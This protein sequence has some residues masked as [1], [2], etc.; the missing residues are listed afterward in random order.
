MINN[1][2]KCFKFTTKTWWMM[3][4][5]LSSGAGRTSVGGWRMGAG[6]VYDG[7]SGVVRSHAWGES[8][9]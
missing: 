3:S 5:V 1:D 4:G 8:E 9:L 6:C 2:E 7:P